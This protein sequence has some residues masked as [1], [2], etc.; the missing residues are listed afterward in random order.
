VVLPEAQILVLI[1]DYC[2]ILGAFLLEPANK[3]EDLETGV[4]RAA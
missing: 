3:K 4:L 2:L 1:K